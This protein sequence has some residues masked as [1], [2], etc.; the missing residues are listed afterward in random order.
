MYLYVF[1]FGLR[2]T[3]LPGNFGSFAKMNIDFIQMFVNKWGP[4]GV[5]LVKHLVPE[6]KN[7]K[8]A[9]GAQ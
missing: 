8:E 4:F 7:F 2:K 6:G 9:F 5:H 3:S 1:T